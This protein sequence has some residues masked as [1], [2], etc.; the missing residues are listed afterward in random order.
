MRRLL[1]TLYVTTEESYLTL[2]GENVVVQRPNLADVRY[3]LCNL[4]EILCFGY[5]GASPALMGKCMENNI[6]L[7]FMSPSGRFL[8]RVIG[9]VK[10]NVYTRI[11]Q[12]ETF[13]DEKKK[14]NLIRDTI[15]AKI[16]N[17][18]FLLAR[19]VRDYA[20]T[21][22]DG[23][24]ERLICKITNAINVIFETSDVDVLRGIEGDVAKDYF[25]IFDRL[26]RNKEFSFSGR[27]KRPPL[28]EVNA[29]LSFL[30]SV[31]SGTISS[32]LECVGIDS[33]IGFFHT[34]RAG[35]FSLALD[36]LEEFR[37]IIDRF[38]LSVINL[39]QL[40]KSDFEHQ[41]GGGV[42]LND[43]GR[44]KIL[45]LWQ[46]KKKEE[47]YHIELKQNIPFG[48]LPFVQANLMGKYLHGEA[49]EYVPFITK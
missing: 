48:I 12:I 2:D 20:E 4:E 17:T 19:S 37:A 40:S 14:L 31:Q 42:F 47:I 9:R 1:N 25:G 38:V 44:K 32:A 43:D 41:L 24:V 28:D 11:A 35:R 15:V 29:C 5:M 36:I 23:A 21:N 34:E 49:D 33:Y 46:D 39:K 22:L 6:L 8:G 45:K 27:S 7:S 18:K 13:K 3:P 30:Y 26:I 16:L 10:G